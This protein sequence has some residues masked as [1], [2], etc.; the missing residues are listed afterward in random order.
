M[1]FGVHKKREEQTEG[2]VAIT[3]IVIDTAQGEAE[4]LIEEAL[5]KFKKFKG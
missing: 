2:M 5:E 4:R 3:P 1:L